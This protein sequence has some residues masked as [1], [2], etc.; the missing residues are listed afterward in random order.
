VIRYEF[1]KHNKS[2]DIYAVRILEGKITGAVGPLHW[3]EQED[4]NLPNFHYDDYLEGVEWF[5]DHQEL[6]DNYQGYKRNA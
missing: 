1:W 6:F 4:K 5:N 3:K 2:G